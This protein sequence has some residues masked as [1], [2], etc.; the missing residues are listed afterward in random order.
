MVNSV[1]YEAQNV[2]LEAFFENDKNARQQRVAF[3]PVK[4]SRYCLACANM[5]ELLA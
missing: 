2:N 5:L 1:C 3:L 4:T